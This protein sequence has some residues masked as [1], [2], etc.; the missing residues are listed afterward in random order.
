MARRGS[1]LAAG[2]ALACLLAGASAAGF[3][4]SSVP[5]LDVNIATLKNT[6]NEAAAPYK[7]KLAGYTQQIN[8]MLANV[9]VRRPGSS[10]CLSRASAPVP[11]RGRE[12]RTVQGCRP[13]GG[14]APR[15]TPPSRRPRKPSIRPTHPPA[16]PPHPPP[17]EVRNNVT[18]PLLA[19]I[20]EK[21]DPVLNAASA[22]ASEHMVLANKAML[23]GG[24]ALNEAKKQ[25]G[26]ALDQGAK[27]VNAAAAQANEAIK[28]AQSKVG[29]IASEVK[30]SVHS[31][32]AANVNSAKSVLALAA[33]GAEKVVMPVRNHIANATGPALESL[34]AT[35]NRAFV[36]ARDAATAGSAQLTNLTAPLNKKLEP[37]TDAMDNAL[38]TVLGAKFS[39][40]RDGVVKAVGAV[41]KLHDKV[42]AVEELI[43]NVTD[44]VRDGA[45]EARDTARG[46]VKNAT[47][48]VT[49]LV[50]KV[51]PGL[52]AP[53]LNRVFASIFEN[54]PAPAERDM[55]KDPKR[56]YDPVW[57]IPQPGRGAPSGEREAQRLCHGAPGLTATA[58]RAR[59][60]ALKLLALRRALAH[61]PR[62]R[63]PS[64]QTLS[65]PPGKCSP[66]KV[67]AGYRHINDFCKAMQSKPKE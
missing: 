52:R 64:P 30:S 9:Q 37:L 48:P 13:A 10:F 19:K 40:V 4:T 44:P 26:A 6:M 50:R 38:G 63:N 58:D 20:H 23:S 17:Q 57:P 34:D 47:S 65:L 27:K 31:L 61:G 14:R 53:E 46:A 24:A 56:E 7:S 32:V 1:R 41:N 62:A 42:P 55:A 5:G 12:P 43:H 29:T 2:L 49:D 15:R 60:S 66:F 39:M 54:L 3:N 59:R 36:A 22:A 51:F 16:R 35:R 8:D 18:N 25:A 11:T 33:E 45:K 67:P 21:V 28:P